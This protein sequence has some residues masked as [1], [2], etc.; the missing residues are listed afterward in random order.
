MDFLPF[1]EQFSEKSFHA[2]IMMR[3]F[4]NFKRFGLERGGRKPE[5]LMH[6]PLQPRHRGH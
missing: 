1:A 3:N 2:H 5:S 4:H 6:E